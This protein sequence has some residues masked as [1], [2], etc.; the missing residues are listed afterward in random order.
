MPIPIPVIDGVLKIGSQLIERWFPDPT[1]AAEA[2]LELAKLYESGELSRLSTEAGLL[3][4]QIEINKIEAASQRLFVSGWRPFIG[5]VC[6]VALFCYY[7]PYT[8]VAT[9]IWAIQSYQTGFLFPRPD[10]GIADLIGLVVTLLGMANLRTKERIE[11]KIP[12]QE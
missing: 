9:T 7:V 6:G 11:G 12:P 4:G 3:H 2:K 8:L 1:K 5:W 10:L